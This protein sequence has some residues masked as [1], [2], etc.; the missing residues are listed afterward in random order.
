[1]AEIAHLALGVADPAA[2]LIFYRTVVGLAGTV[3]RDGDGFL[4]TTPSGFVFA[5]LPGQR[6]VDLGW[7]HFG[8]RLADPAAVA[9]KRLELAAKGLPEV[10]WW[11]EPG[12]TSL[13]VE[14]PDGYVIEFFA[15]DLPADPNI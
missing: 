3:H 4:L 13:K 12:L 8:V 11:E 5:L 1:M 6:P 15:D 7:V 9:D 14:D 2:S 10:D